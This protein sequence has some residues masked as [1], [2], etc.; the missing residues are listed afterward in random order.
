M[1]LGFSKNI[2]YLR[3]SPPM[4]QRWKYLFVRVCITWK[5][6]HWSCLSVSVASTLLMFW[7][8]CKQC[9]L[10]KTGWSL[11]LSAGFRETLNQICTDWGKVGI[12]T[13]LIIIITIIPW[14]NRELSIIIICIFTCDWNY[15]KEKKKVLQYYKISN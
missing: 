13:I 4:R 2:V 8:M 11:L 15:A 14:W 7:T 1:H 3:P 10:E 6:I 12:I 9:T 5:C